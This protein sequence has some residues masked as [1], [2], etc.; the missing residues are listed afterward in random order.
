VATTECTRI[1]ELMM[2]YL[3][4]ELDASAAAQFRSHVDGCTR[5]STEL[6]GLERTRQAIRSLPE[7]D[8]PPSVTALLLHE[9]AKRSSRDEGAEKKGVWAWLMGVFQPI[10]AHPA[11]AAAASLILVAGVAGYLSMKGLVSDKSAS[12]TEDLRLE[13][14]DKPMNVVLQGPEAGEAAGAAPGDVTA[15]PEGDLGKRAG[16][17]GGDGLYDLEQNQREATG[18]TE[19]KDQASRRGRIAPEEEQQK[20]DPERSKSKKKPIGLRQDKAADDASFGYEDGAGVNALTPPP[21]Q[22]PARKSAGKG[23]GGFAEAPKAAERPSEPTPEPAPPPQPVAAPRATSSTT[24]SYGDRGQGSA[25]GAVGGAAQPSAPSK[26]SAHKPP[27]PQATPASPAAVN[28][29]ADWD[30]APASEAEKP[31]TK[32]KEAAAPA[33]DSKAQKSSSQLYQEAQA[34]AKAKGGCPTALRLRTEISRVDPEYYK[35][36]VL[37]DPL[38]EKCATSQNRDKQRRAPAKQMESAP[39]PADSYDEPASTKSAH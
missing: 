39:A 17:E 22:G 15:L 14:K 13:E 19:S 38:L 10:G 1:D 4:R 18:T 31:T 6:A 20:L 36:R 3:Y 7:A 23:A 24:P 35:K 37:K 29:K 11:L 5:C 30:E 34:A 8:P 32:K 28:T 16:G 26:P 21:S 12:S 33:K 9:A 27:P 25:S 2:E